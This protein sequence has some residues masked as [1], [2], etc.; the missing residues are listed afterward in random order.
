MK[1][2]KVVL[3]FILAVF[4]ATQSFAQI[5]LSTQDIIRQSISKSATVKAEFFALEQARNL[6]RGLKSGFNPYLEL[7]PGV[8]FTNGNSILSQEFDLFG[9]RSSEAKAS[10][11]N[12]IIFESRILAAELE[13]GATALSKVSGYLFAVEQLANAEQNLMSSNAILKAVQ[14]RVEIGEAPKVHE[15]RAEVEVLRAE[16]LVS[17]S[18]LDLSARVAEINSMIGQPIE[19][20]IAVS[21]WVFAS[22]LEPRNKLPI[23][24][25]RI[26]E[27]ELESAKAQVRAA[28]TLG[29]P[30]FSAGIASDFWSLDRPASRN[31]SVGLQ[32]FLRVPLGDRGENRYAVRAAESNVARHEELLKEANRMAGLEKEIALRAL[33]SAKGVSTLYEKGIL[34]KADHMLIA[35]RQGYETGL[36]SLLEVLEAQQTLQR[37]QRESAESSHKLR[38]AE[39]RYLKATALIPGIEVK[40]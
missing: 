7:G 19:N 15:T 3:V 38:L 39:T 36:I 25:Q 10:A 14:K 4:L 16:Q 17:E 11:A 12:A 5:K 40:N 30:T 23:P 20:Q 29:K 13:V 31:Q 1:N 8:G 27:A 33:T 26:A 34:P 37:L 22:P 9:R 21:D 28:K 24:L 35:M 2:S 6:Q 32:F 18:K